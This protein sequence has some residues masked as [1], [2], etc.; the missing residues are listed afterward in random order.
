MDS[1]M[2]EVYF[3]QYCKTCLHKDVKD[4]ER[5]CCDCLEECARQDSHK[6]ARWEKSYERKIND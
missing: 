4:T 1:N 5:P 6:P 3:D 2:K